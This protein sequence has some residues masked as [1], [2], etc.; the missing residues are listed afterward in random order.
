MAEIQ[1]LGTIR[2]KQNYLFFRRLGKDGQRTGKRTYWKIK[3]VSNV[4]RE[5]FFKIVGFLQRS[6]RQSGTKSIDSVM[7]A[8]MLGLKQAGRAFGCE[9]KKRSK[10]ADLY[11][12][13]GGQRLVAWQIHESSLNERRVRKLMKSKAS[14]RI[15][16]VMKKGGYFEIKP[17]R[18]KLAD[19]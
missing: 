14:L 15:A 1:R 5:L 19:Q 9:I 16:V 10:L 8:G 7:A 18:T 2:L 3:E 6:I 11:W 4:P 17:Q 12:S 13:L